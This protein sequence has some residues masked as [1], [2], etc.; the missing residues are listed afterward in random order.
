MR[1]FLFILGSLL[2]VSF[3]NL[4]L[5]LPEPPDGFAWHKVSAIQGA[6][7][8]P[9]G[10]YFRADEEENAPVFF[11]TQDKYTPP[12]KFRVGASL[13]AFPGFSDLPAMIE[14]HLRRRADHHSVELVP[15]EFGPFQTLQCQY[16]L[17]KTADHG[18]IRV[19]VLGIVNPE[20]QTSY[21]VFFESPVE[22]RGGPQTLDSLAA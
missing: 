1:R 7:L 17:P 15:G 12:P 13:S 8:V 9:D 6:L 18:A 20:T 10:W 21:L 16:D 19:F 4:A 2:S 14:Q 5:E 3:L 22:E 11:I